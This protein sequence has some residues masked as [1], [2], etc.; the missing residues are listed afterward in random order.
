MRLKFFILWYCFVFCGMI[1]GQTDSA[2]QEFLSP[3]RNGKDEMAEFVGGKM[4]WKKYISE[5]YVF[6][7]RCE[8]AGL[9]GVVKVG[10][11]V[12]T[13]GSLTNVQVISGCS[14]CIEFEE[15]AVRIIQQSPRWKPAKQQGKKVKSYI[16]MPINFHFNN[17]KRTE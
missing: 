15:E 5:Q 16:E 12:E 6:P 10:F 4:G 7:E 9:S 11:Y 8:S 13:D 1:Y 17:S 2:I 3:Q 14:E